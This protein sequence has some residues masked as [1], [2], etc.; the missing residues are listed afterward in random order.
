[1][2]TDTPY[3]EG[4]CLEL[5][6]ALVRYRAHLLAHHTEFVVLEGLLGAFLR[7]LIR[8]CH[9]LSIENAAVK[10]HDATDRRTHPSR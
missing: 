5:L 3:L 10:E 9:A 2:T 1:M 6:T 8:R 4:R 7:S